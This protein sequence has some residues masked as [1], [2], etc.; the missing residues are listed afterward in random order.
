VSDPDSNRASACTAPERLLLPW[1]VTGRLDPDD[2]ARVD[3]HLRDC[4]ECRAAQAVERSLAAVVA[5]EDAV[6]PS[7]AAPLNAF[8]ARLERERP[9]ARTGLGR[10]VRE[11]R[12]LVGAVAVQALV[13]AGL[14]AGLLVRQPPAEYA[15]LSR[16]PTA[17]AGTLHVVFDAD[18]SLA[19]VQTALA[20]AGA[21]IVDGPGEAGVYTL[22]TAAGAPPGDALETLRSEPIVRFASPVAGGTP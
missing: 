1:S 21:R 8:M 15:T 19:Q 9:S 5:A 13:I 22:A 7:P 16:A 10:R 12:L 17:A 20:R 11:R 2:A 6:T 3:A 14:V 18:A 4:A